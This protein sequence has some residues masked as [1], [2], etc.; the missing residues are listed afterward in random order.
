MVVALEDLGY[1]DTFDEIYACSAGAVNS[2]YFVTRNAW[3]PLTIYFD[4]LS[5]GEFVDFGRMLRGRAPMNL[6]YVFDDVLVKRKPLDYAAIISAPQRLHVM[7]TDVDALKPLDVKEFTSPE[8]LRD[9]LRASVWMPVATK[10]TAN[11]RGNR[12]MDGAILQFHPFR[13]AMLD[14]CTH[15]LS[16]STRPIDGISARIPLS[17]R[18]VAWHLERM[19]TGLGDGLLASI[20]QYMTEDRPRLV[21]NRLHPDDNPAVLDLAPLPGTPTVKRTETN[22]GLLLNGARSAY[23]LVYF[24]LDD[25]DV[26][27][28]PKLTVH[29]PAPAPIID[30]ESRPAVHEPVAEPVIDTEPR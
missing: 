22:T 6:D 2:A 12:A 1:A 13:A 16:L 19:R 30:T 17:N 29:E 11:F 4:D 20:R 21:R 10:G 23:R 7:V 28:A 9:A 5:S 14:G 15:I 3:F 18:L 24:A 26:V 25:R 27:V 8:D